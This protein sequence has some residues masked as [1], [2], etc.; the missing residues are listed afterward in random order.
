MTP[1][2]IL[3]LD[4]FI[5]LAGSARTKPDLVGAAVLG[6]PELPT[7]KTGFEP[8]STK[9]DPATT[10]T[11]LSTP[12]PE[13]EPQAEPKNTDVADFAW[14]VYQAITALT[15]RAAEPGL[16]PRPTAQAP[17]TG[18][19]ADAP[20][21]ATRPLP[22]PDSR[23]QTPDSQGGSTLQRD[24]AMPANGAV[25]PVNLQP[26]VQTCQRVNVLTCQRPRRLETHDSGL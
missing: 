24:A 22:N 12:D 7:P 21:R 26:D 6:P 3:T 8:G 5:S 19:V 16:D 25:P 9:H 23:L 4:L 14:R 2:S 17:N 1:G 18:L 20:S 11:S 13:S 15:S 10:P